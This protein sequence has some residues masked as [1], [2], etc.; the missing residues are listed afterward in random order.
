M[1]V[2]GV[3]S[4]KIRYGRSAL[5][6]YFVFSKILHGIYGNFVKSMSFASIFAIF[7]PNKMFRLGQKPR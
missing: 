2:S 6:F 7:F 4:E 3:S 1:Y 5:L